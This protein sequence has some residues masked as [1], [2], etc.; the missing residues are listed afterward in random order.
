MRVANEATII[1]PALCVRPER[2]LCS[3]REGSRLLSCYYRRQ[4]LHAPNREGWRKRLGSA[5]ESRESDVRFGF[6]GMF[7][8]LRDGGRGAPSGG[9]KCE[10]EFNGERTRGLP[11]R[12]EFGR[13]ESP[14]RRLAVGVG[15]E[16]SAGGTQEHARVIRVRSPVEK[17]R[18]RGK[19]E[20]RPGRNIRISR[21][22]RWTWGEPEGSQLRRRGC[23]PSI[24]EASTNWLVS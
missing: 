14:L 8:A 20:S 18:P 4:R 10:E 12:P 6:R 22:G 5:E 9:G 2:Y 11:L 3:G 15:G 1:C 7:L 21:S 24:Y 19:I 13:G 23:R 17:R 16:T